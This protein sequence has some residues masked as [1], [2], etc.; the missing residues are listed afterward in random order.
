MISRIRAK[1]LVAQVVVVL[2]AVIALGAVVLAGRF[3][4]Q[5]SQGADSASALHEVA[6]LPPDAQHL[7][8]WEPDA[9]TRDRQLEPANR[10]LVE[11]AYIRAWAA[12]GHLQSTGSDEAL[13]DTF[14][15]R[16]RAQVLA[17]PRDSAVAT[18]DLGHELTLQFYALDG[19]TI[20]FTDGDAALARTVDTG[21]TRTVVVTHERY[22]VVMALV[23]G[24][25]RID[26]LRR[27]GDGGVVTVRTTTVD[28]AVITAVTGADPRQPVDAP[29]FRAA[30]F[31][32]DRWD[33][34]LTVDGAGA[35]IPATTATGRSGPTDGSADA[36]GTGELSVAGAGTGASPD[37][38]WTAAEVQAVGDTLRRAA[39]LGLTAVRV[40]VNYAA[41]GGADPTDA[42]L[43]NLTTLFEEAE[44][45]GIGVVPVL[46]DGITDLSPAGWAGADRHLRQLVAT[47][48]N[49]P[50]LT[51]WDLMDDP[52]GRTAAGATATDVR[53]FLVIGAT[54]LHGL[55]PATPVTISW[56]DVAGATDPAMVGLVD[57]VSLRVDGMDADAVRSSVAPMTAAADGR[58]L[59]WVSAGPATDGGWGPFPRTPAAQSAALADLLS[60][61]RADGVARLS[62]AAV[63]DG[64]ATGARGVVAADGTAKPAAALLAPDAA[65]ADVP[66][67]GLGDYLGSRFWQAVSLLAVL[68]AGL[69]A[70]L[71]RRRR[72]PAPAGAVGAG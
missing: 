12:L 63:M 32:P 31:R 2:G 67:P 51:A 69:T 64:P 65:L 72:R 62:T 54:R 46:F 70:L 41:M 29:G 55:D 58:P 3:V 9:W 16:A 21:D 5:A 40:P 36:D 71:L 44:A 35:A 48:R 20:A 19:G 53:A 45:A 38:R 27:G 6:T 25:W 15:A 61:A 68:A 24:Y 56:P 50:A 10:T 37:G 22:D 52:D 30:E 18:W 47:V 1:R 60:S 43:D 13:T 34:S 33:T 28:D 42:A 57:V 17:M 39:H 26:Q 66:G 11:A 23:D 8:S 59:S 7:V 4:L 14:T 49:S